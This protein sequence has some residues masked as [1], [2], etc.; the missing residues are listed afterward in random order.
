MAAFERDHHSQLRGAIPGVYYANHKRGPSDA[1]R[2]RCDSGSDARPRQS[3]PTASATTATTTKSSREKERSRSRA[4][5]VGRGGA[6]S[7]LP[8]TLVRPAVTRGPLCG[9]PDQHSFHHRKPR[10]PPNTERR[11]DAI[12]QSAASPTPSGEQPHVHGK[13]RDCGFND[14]GP[15]RL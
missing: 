7:L 10:G 4:C 15:G 9:F 6:S 13:G 11:L 2:T 3:T 8:L 1:S 14:A 5:A 12:A